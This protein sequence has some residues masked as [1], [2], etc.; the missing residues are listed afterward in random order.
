MK[1]DMLYH[2]CIILILFL[3]IVCDS[4]SLNANGFVMQHLITHSKKI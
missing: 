2:I 4:V 1:L 3:Q